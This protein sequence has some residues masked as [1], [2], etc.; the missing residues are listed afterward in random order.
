[1]YCVDLLRTRQYPQ[2]VQ[3]R[4]ATESQ[5]EEKVK[6]STEVCPLTEYFSSNPEACLSDEAPDLLQLTQHTRRNFQ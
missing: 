3:M 4:R 2:V 5:Q 6:G 1:M